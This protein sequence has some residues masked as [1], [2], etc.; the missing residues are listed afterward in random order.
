MRRN[1]SPFIVD[2]R[3]I[4]VV[5]GLCIFLSCFVSLFSLVSVCVVVQVLCCTCAGGRFEDLVAVI[6]RTV[7]PRCIF[8][9]CNGSPGLFSTSTMMEEGRWG[10]GGH[11]DFYHTLSF[12]FFL[13]KK[14]LIPFFSFL[15]FASPFDANNPD[16]IVPLC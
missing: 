7:N 10:E 12:R 9:Y 15:Y 3:R 11:L 8:F 4:P 14:T 5:R 13:W 6:H 16:C 2:L 1:L